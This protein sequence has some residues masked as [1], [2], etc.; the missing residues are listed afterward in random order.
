LTNLKKNTKL[1]NIVGIARSLKIT[2]QNIEIRKGDYNDKESY[3]NSDFEIITGRKHLS[4][5]Q[6]AK[7]FKNK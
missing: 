7:T 1:S 3:I 6:M 4:V 2:D 5:K